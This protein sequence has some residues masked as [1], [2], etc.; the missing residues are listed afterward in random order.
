VGL[1]NTGKIMPSKYKS[2][3]IS[4]ADLAPK[5]KKSAAATATPPK[6]VCIEPSEIMLPKQ[7]NSMLCE[8]LEN[9]EPRNIPKTVRSRFNGL[10]QNAIK[11]MIRGISGTLQSSAQGADKRIQEVTLT[12]LQ[13]LLEEKKQ[14]GK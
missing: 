2:E 14:G 9:T 10:S 4:F 8:L 5:R 7:W 6:T 3:R 13:E 12:A 1:I 11:Q